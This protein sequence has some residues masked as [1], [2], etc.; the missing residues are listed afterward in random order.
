[1]KTKT[2]SGQLSASFRDP[3]GFLF[4]RNDVL[5]RQVNRKYEQEY[6]RLM[7]SGLYEKLVKAK[8]L[9]PHV[10]A[11]A[12]EAESGECFK[13]LQPERVAFIS[14]PYEWSFGQLK[15]AALATLSIQKRA[16]KLDMS[17][18]DASAYNIQYVRG[19]PTLIDTL[20]FEL[21]KEGQP[22]VAYRQFCQHFLAPLSL[23]A[24]RDVRLNQLLRVYIDGVPLDLASELLPWKT[25][26]NFGLM[27]HIH[28]HAGAQKKYAGE[29]VK[30]R[31]GSMSKQAMAGLIE[32]LESTVKKLEWKPGG[33]EWGN[34]YDITNYSDAAFEHKKQL[35]GEWTD[36]IR[37]SIVWDL[38]ANNGVF[39][40]VA[41]DAQAVPAVTSWDI[42]PAAVEQNYRQ[43]KT[44]KNERVLPLLLDLTNPS[45]AIGWANRERDS[46]GGRGPADLT[47]ALAV[48][49]HLAI[50]NNVPLLQLAGFFAE[51]GKWLVIEFVPK[52]DSQV[53]KL[54]ASRED[55]FPDYTREGFE[56][57]FSQRFKVHD[58]VPVRESERVLYLMEGI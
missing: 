21:Y 56:E 29:E 1:M 27:T 46:F 37:P 13:I 44:E 31:G 34:Y 28:L 42:D 54:L 24:L 41:A 39:S 47:L 50:S 18:K 26:L 58:A 17:L 9:I 6:V 35:V 53:Q 14:Y 36:R 8:L 7:E 23:M 16:L 15:D 38:G 40:R 52:S 3:S 11:E 10:E 48:I 4:K 45:P 57:A 32:S 51:T 55:I 19:K 22:W 20:S 12:V 33:T 2:N 25:H 30:S 49:H 5:Y 43:V